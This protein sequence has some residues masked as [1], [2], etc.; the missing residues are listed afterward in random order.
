MNVDLSDKK[1]I[2]NL[3]KQAALPAS[4][5]TLHFDTDQKH[6]GIRVSANGSA[7]W[8]LER[9]I[10]KKPVRRTLGSATGAQ[11]MS[12]KL[13]IAE[14]NIINGKLEEGRDEVAERKAEKAAEKAIPTSI[15]FG[16]ALNDY[17]DRKIRQ[18][19]DKALK[20]RTKDD[21]LSF[22][23]AP[24]ALK[25][26]KVT[27]AG[28]LYALADI[29]L[30]Q[31]TADDIRAVHAAAVLRCKGEN[32]RRANYAMTILRAILRWH[33]T[34]I[35]DNP[36]S[37]E[38]AGAKRVTIKPARSAKNPIKLK[39]VGAW[40]QAAGDARSTVASDALKAMLLSGCRPGE[41][42]GKD[43]LRVR[44]VDL[45][46]GTFQLPDPKNRRPHVVYCSTQLLEI[47]KRNVADKKPDALVFDVVDTGKSFTTICTAAGLAESRHV[48][49]DLRATF[50]SIAATLV[51]AA[52]L[53]VMMNHIGQGDVTS[54]HYVE[55]EEEQLR[56]GW[57]AVADRIE[58][59]K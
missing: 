6:F 46:A 40:W 44:H 47:L 3:V 29:P 21:Y 19:D 24:T 51:P 15:T 58:A 36:L 39:Q 7:S 53:K 35:E 5:Y 54:D 28:M 31:I 17:V 9:R 22:I 20:A 12:Y 25:N 48:P 42:T 1:V 4:G 16:Q 14:F 55:I 2:S 27:R 50:A 26:G 23:A 10:N 18:K 30:N 11:A 52:V 38:T 37:I 13:A 56:A 41:L 32:K 49:S 34:H 43:A 59:Q 57:Q 45:K 33:G 8:I